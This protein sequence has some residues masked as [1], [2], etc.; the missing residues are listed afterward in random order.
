MLFPIVLLG[1]NNFL[2]DTTKS[3]YGNIPTFKEYAI[4][5]SSLTSGDTSWYKLNNK[6]VDEKT[7]KKFTQFSDNINKCRPCILLS[8]DT[9]ENLLFKRISYGDCTVGYWIEYYLNGKVKVIGHFKENSSG[10]WDNIFYRGFCRKDG[11]WIYFD[12]NGNKTKSEIWKEGKLVKK[13]VE[14]K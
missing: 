3:I 10:S 4:S 12:E 14:K 13:K 11:N 5:S 2:I 9:S 8:Y 7:Y 6:V 1:Q